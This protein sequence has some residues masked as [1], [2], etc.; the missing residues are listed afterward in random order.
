MGGAAMD[1]VS[2]VVSSSGARMMVVS[3]GAMVTKSMTEEIVGVVYDLRW[4]VA[5][6]VVLIIFDFW[7]GLSESLKNREHFRVS[8]AGRRTCNKFMDYIG[9]L[10]LGAFFGLGI[11]EPLGIATHVQTAAVALGFGC[12]WE[13]DSIVGHVC[14]LHGVKNHF[15]VKR[16]IIALLKK[17]NEDVGEAVEEMFDGEG[18]KDDKQ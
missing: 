14:A 16:F 8:R 4:M 5:L 18:G 15:S 10:I 17:K 7:Y 13:I 11:F 1:G 3:G 12:L 6:V 9:Y 2:G